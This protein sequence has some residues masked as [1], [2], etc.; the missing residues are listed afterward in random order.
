MEKKLVLLLILVF[1]LVSL[2][3]VQAKDFDYEQASEA[4]IDYLYVEDAF[5]KSAGSSASDWLAFGMGRHGADADYAAYLAVLENKVS[6]RYLTKEKLSDT[7]AT[8]WHRIALTVL[9]LGGDPTAFGEDESGEPINLIADGVYNRGEVT[10]LAEQGIN[11]L[12]WGLLT[13]DAL[14]Y[15]VAEDAYENREDIIERILEL[16]LEDGGF[17]LKFPP[18]DI[19][20]TAMVLQALAPYYNSE[21]TYTYMRLSDQKQRTVRV[22]EVIDEALDLLS[23]RQT[24]SAGFESFGLENTESLVQVIVALTALQIDPLKDQRFIKNNQTLIDN[25]SRYQQ[26]DGGFIHSETYDEDNPTAKPDQSNKMASEQAL[27]GLSSLIRFENNLRRLYDFRPEPSDELKSKIESLEI[28]IDALNK[29]TSAEHL[30]KIFKDYQAIPVDERSYVSN[31]AKLSELLKRAKISVNLD[32]SWGKN[33]AGKGTITPLLTDAHKSDPGFT[34]ADLKLYQ[35]LPKEI[36]TKDEIT[37]IKLLDK[38]KEELKSRSANQSD[39]ENYKKELEERMQVI[40]ELKSEINDLNQTIV[41]ELYP[42]ESIK[43][44]DKEKVEAIQTR[45][46]ALSEHDQSL[47]QNYE[48]LE[49][50][51]TE[52]KSLERAR[53]IRLLGIFLLLVLSYGLIKG[54][55]KR[56]KRKTD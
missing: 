41:D 54:R 4:V 53:W 36:T 17:S 27:Y 15:E 47:I 31:Y 24:E 32:E 45:Y 49:K 37:V 10:D 22:R 48:A 8:E 25:L 51:V 28:E 11:G 38:L 3:S 26:A 43:A 5:L 50:A 30:K 14:D 29:N 42:F 9:A 52:I 56:K 20:L 40:D 13:L 2:H 18:S 12:S 7:K 6:E 16:Q 55:R 35:S 34:Q 46:L 33:K 39:Y 19:D 44:E 23:K 21:K 1:S